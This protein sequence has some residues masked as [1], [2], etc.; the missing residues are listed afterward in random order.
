M[1]TFDLIL[2]QLE[3]EFVQKLMQSNSIDLLEQLRLEFLG[4][5]GILPELNEQLKAMTIEQK[6]TYGPLLQQLRADVEL[7]LNDSIKRLT[8]ANI[9]MM[10]SKEANFDITTSLER[11]N[12]G[13]IHP[14]TLVA[15]ELEDIFISMGFEIVQGR[16]VED[17]WYNFQALNIP[18]D[19][20]ARDAHDTFWLENLPNRLLRTHTS[21]VQ[22]HTMQ[23]KRPPLAIFS[24]GRVFRNE[25]TDASHDFMFMQG[26][27]LLIDKNISM[28][29]LLSC[30]QNFLQAL[31]DKKD[32][33]IRVRP[34]YF[35]FVE[36]GVEIDASC[37]FCK[38]G[39]S[40]C[41]RSGWIE[42]SGAGLVHPNVLR[43]CNI[44]PTIYSGFAMGFGLSRLAMLKYGIS[45]TRLFHDQRL[46]ILD[47]F[48]FLR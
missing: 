26:E 30:A 11:Q 15:R 13:S 1:L 9:A 14:L 5:K 48:T 29:H 44:D 47:Q 27:P 31:F 20:P 7:K 42:I 34:S 46:H 6:R 41:K 25:A 38:I 4:K 33:K 19:H 32:L 36:P 16:E 23:Q 21:T 3:K 40:V 35:P 39:C 37:P 17:D 43:A 24:Y 22:I 8:E 10:H 45:D 12:Q 28:A 2:A 18:H